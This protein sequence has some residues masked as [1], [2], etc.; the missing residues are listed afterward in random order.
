MTELLKIY[1]QITQ[2]NGNFKHTTSTTNRPFLKHGGYSHDTEAACMEIPSETLGL[3][4]TGQDAGCSKKPVM[5][6][7]MRIVYRV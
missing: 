2:V 6:L 4:D 1:L 7:K 5:R 3:L